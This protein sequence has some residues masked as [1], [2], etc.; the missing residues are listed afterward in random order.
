VEEEVTH[1]EAVNAVVEA[2]M[3]WR[4]DWN[5]Q[6]WNRRDL[7]PLNLPLWDAI[8]ALDALP[9]EP[10][11]DELNAAVA[12]EVAERDVRIAQVER[13]RADLQMQLDASCNAEELRQARAERDALR[14]EVRLHDARLQII[15][16]RGTEYGVLNERG[17]YGEWKEMLDECMKRHFPER[18]EEARRLRAKNEEAGR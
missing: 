14:A 15:F 3:A 18:L 13:E 8:D 5:G 11:L 9:A 10:D 7:N 4:R 2:A 6:H 17:T 16:H 1:R 12:E